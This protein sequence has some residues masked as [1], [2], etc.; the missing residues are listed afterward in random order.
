VEQKKS[1]DAI[2]P[3]IGTNLL[4]SSSSEAKQLVAFL[5]QV[6]EASTG[7]NA[8]SAESIGTTWLACSQL[9]DREPESEVSLAFERLSDAYLATITTPDDAD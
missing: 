1:E 4:K 8:D 6:Y 7:N 3:P 2:V 5:A 9:I